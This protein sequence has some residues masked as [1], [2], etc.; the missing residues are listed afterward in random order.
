M[1]ELIA[2]LVVDLSDQTLYAY[3]PQQALIRTVRGVGYVLSDEGED[4]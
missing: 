4:A 3:N 1:V 2:A